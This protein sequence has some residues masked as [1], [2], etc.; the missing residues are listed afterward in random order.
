MNKE[1]RPTDGAGPPDAAPVRLAVFEGTEAEKTHLSILALKK[2]EDG[3][4]TLNIGGPDIERMKP[5]IERFRDERRKLAKNGVPV[6]RALLSKALTGLLTSEGF[7]VE[8][9][10]AAD[11]QINFQLDQQTGKMVGTHTALHPLAAAN[12]DAARNTF[13]AIARSLGN[14]ANQTADEIAKLLAAGDTDGAASVVK[15]DAE[16]GLLAL[17]ASDRLLSALLQIDVAKLSA[18]QR[19]SVR[20]ARYL[21]ASRFGNFGIAGPEADHI[22]EE[23]KGSLDARYIANL[24]MASGL[25]ALERGQVETAL[26]IW[27]EI[28]REPSDLD[29]EGRAWALRNISNTLSPDDP[30]ALDT[31]RRSSDAFL[32]SGNKPEASKSLFRV[33]NILMRKEPSEAVVALDEMI[34]LL[35][36]EGLNDRYI[37]AAALFGGAIRLAALGRHNEALRDAVEAADLQRGLLGAESQLISALHLV[38]MEAR[39]IGDTEKADA[40]A[41]EAERLSDELKIPHFEL[42]K[43]LDALAKNFNE[44]AADELVRDAEQI[45]KWEV[46]AMVRVIQATLERFSVDVNRN[47]KGVP[48]GAQ[49]R[50]E[51]L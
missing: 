21:T 26:E 51:L 17:P 47:S 6:D 3:N 49:I 2:G 43:R 12:A 24:K 9:L 14:F 38:S 15:R 8:E 33:A 35:D 34:A 36:N 44:R 27:R 18:T 45:N 25:G 46:T 5:Y 13:E 37:R 42:S 20:E 40:F 23:D 19:F 28:L 48:R 31:A 10:P 50:F 39:T 4:W 30:E 11:H 7:I 29:T 41:A 16:R 1:E 22:L 32:A